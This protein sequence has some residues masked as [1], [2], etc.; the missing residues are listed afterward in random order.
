MSDPTTQSQEAESCSM[1]S[2]KKMNFRIPVLM[3]SRF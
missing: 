3:I 2:T 1:T